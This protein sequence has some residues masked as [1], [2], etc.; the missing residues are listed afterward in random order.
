MKSK[1]T[2][3]AVAIL[4]L[5]SAGCS[6]VPQY[7]RPELAVPATITVPATGPET[8]AGT[9]QTIVSNLSWQDAFTDPLLRKLIETALAN[10][11]D[12]REAALNVQ[13]YQ[14]KY[15]IQRA[16]QLPTLSVDGYGR[17]QRTLS[18]GGYGTSEVYSIDLGTTSYELDFYGRVSSLKNQ[19]LEL[20]LAMDETRKS[21]ALSLI[22][23]VANTYLTW[24]ADKELLQI[25]EDTCKTREESYRLIQQRVGAGISSELD[26][27]QAR[28]SLE[29]V[30]SNLALYRRQVVQDTNYLTL[31]TGS[32]LPAEMTG[33]TVRLSEVTIMSPIGNSLSSETLLQRPDIIAAEHELIAAN[34]SIGAARAAFFP[35]IKITTSAGF[36]SADL[37]DLIDNGS[38]SWLF[39]PSISIPIFNAGQLQAELDAAVIRKNISIARYEKA[40]QNAFQEVADGLINVSTYR[41]QLEAQEAN[42]AANEEYYQ[43]ASDRYREGVDS[44]LT[45][46]DAQRSL[47][48]ARQSY[49]SLKLAKLQTQVNLY[50][51][52]GGGGKDAT[53]PLPQVVSNSSS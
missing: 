41:D 17:K 30:R 9:A 26:L 27:A 20:Y 15:R 11:R 39:S 40:I 7:Q 52:L 33:D 12:L 37:S 6:M 2:K 28:T 51:A 16:A 44:F 38:G 4:L 50:K 34:A 5:F 10:N 19:A 18:G 8:F 53:S 3:L 48:S 25:T 21:A 23:D 43:R 24:L 45:L 46:L 42:L 29:S 32:P 14:A 49:L 13:A 1:P 31:L 36:I 35:S 47:Y 22:G